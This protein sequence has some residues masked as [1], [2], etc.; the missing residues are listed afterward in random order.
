MHF[1]VLSWSLREF[2]PAACRQKTPFSVPFFGFPGLTSVRMALEIALGISRH[3]STF[4]ST[5]FEPSGFTR[6]SK[7]IIL[8]EDCA[9]S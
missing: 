1:I 5:F 9:K 6:G 8:R 3:G 2:R 7:S 4:D